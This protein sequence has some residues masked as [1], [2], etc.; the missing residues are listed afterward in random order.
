VSDTAA[1]QAEAR[2]GLRIGYLIGADSHRGIARGG[3][4]VAY[5]GGTDIFRLRTREPKNRTWLH[6]TRNHFRQ[7]IRYDLDR[8][9]V[10]LNLVTDPDI[11]PGVLEVLAKLTSGYAG[12]LINPP[13]KILATSRER[14]AGRLAGIPDVYAP[15][16]LRMKAA[17]TGVLARK[18][19][20][21]GFRFPAILRLTGTH[22][23]RILGLIRNRDELAGRM[24]RGR[25]HYLTEFVDCRSPDGFYR[26][27]RFW[28]FGRGIV[29]RSLMIS[30]QWSVHSK[31]NLKLKEARP[32]LMREGDEAVVAGAAGLAK[33]TQAA[34][35]RIGETMGLDFFG[36]DCVLTPQGRIVLFEANA[37]MN[38]FAAGS[39]S[40][41]YLH[42]AVLQRARRAFDK[43]LFGGE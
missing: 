24:E 16:T 9:D 42:P 15:K 23:G 14:I 19:D 11:N 17:S 40:R 39:T 2:S 43:M 29:M 1:G 6:V 41:A 35:M 10:L 20:E 3:E 36:V 18:L 33:P 12:R 34:L 13:E 32:D 38:F 37:T 28:Y 7:R 8:F 25:E 31:D 30:P 21:A 26:K 4:K 22:T 27:W 5:Q